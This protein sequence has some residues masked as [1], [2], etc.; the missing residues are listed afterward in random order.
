MTKRR[1]RGE[2]A[3]YQRHD[4]PTCPPVGPD[5]ERPDHNCRGRWVGTLDLGRPYGGGKRRRKPIYGKTKAEVQRKLEK[6]KAEHRAS[7]LIVSSPTV[8]QWMRYWLDNIA[9]ERVRDRTLANY[10]SYVETHIIPG[11]GR[12]RLDKL[13]PGHVREL[14]SVMRKPCPSPDEKTKRCAHR[15]VHGR[16]E[17]TIR[18]THAIL[19]RALKVAMRE[20]KVARNVCDMIDPPGT[21]KNTP[22]P[23]TVAEARKVLRAAKG[24][25]IESRWY[26]ALW[27]G[28][29]QGEVLGLRWTDVDIE[30]GLIYV[31]QAVQRQTGKGLVVT[32]LK[33]RASRRVIP[34]PNV[35]LAQLT[36]AWAQHVNAGGTDDAYV[37]PAADG[38]PMDPK[39]DWEAWR[40]LLAKAEVPMV[41]LHAARNTAGSL[42]LAAGVDP[43][44][45]SE[46]LGHSTVQI[47]QNVYQRG[48]LSGHRAALDAVGQLVVDDDGE[49]ET[50]AL[51]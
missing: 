40:R 27:L 15:P 41:R 36:V 24:D 2:G 35:V 38:G 12:H 37:W 21:Y 50:P 6:A 4:A 28:M 1:G 18:Q 32:E 26:V 49:D 16:A 3:V 42:L 8:E 29:R 19:S 33:S 48:E 47:T 10:R 9:V 39:R 11:I 30:N 34:L 51:P 45:V 44:I 23:L 7:A 17:A 43:K 5:G 20:G 22:Q 46:I 13:E 31:R 25:A 14:Y